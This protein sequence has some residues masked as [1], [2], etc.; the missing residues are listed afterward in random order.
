MLVIAFILAEHGTARST[1][2][3]LVVHG[4]GPGLFRH[5]AEGLQQRLTV[6]LA[7][8]DEHGKP[9]L[10]LSEVRKYMEELAA[11]LAYLH[12]NGMAGGADAHR[13]GTGCFSTVCILVA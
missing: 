1:M 12:E 2:M 10:P 6:A 11:G 3:R 9:A 5:Y 4:Y 7:M 8:Q 13:L